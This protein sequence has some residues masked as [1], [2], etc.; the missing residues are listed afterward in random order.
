[1]C[2]ATPVAGVDSRCLFVIVC[3]SAGF[4]EVYAKAGL[5]ASRTCLFADSRSACFVHGGVHQAT[6]PD[7]GRDPQGGAFVDVDAAPKDVSENG[8]DVHHY[9]RS[10][11]IKDFTC[12][13]CI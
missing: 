4:P 6:G 7:N 8:G 3:S 10:F 13:S 1:M 5:L 9:S 2:A 11:G 12:K